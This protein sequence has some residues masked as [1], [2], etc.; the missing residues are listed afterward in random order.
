MIAYLSGAVAAGPIGRSFA[1]VRTGPMRNFNT[2]LDWVIPP[3]LATLIAIAGA[4]IV[5]VPK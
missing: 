4:W 5:F 2:F 1:K 3:A